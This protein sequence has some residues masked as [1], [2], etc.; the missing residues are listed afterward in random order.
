MGI[1]YVMPKKLLCLSII[2]FIGFFIFG[3][4]RTTDTGIYT[5]G[6]G[7]VVGKA[8][9]KNQ[10]THSGIVVSVVGT[11]FLGTTTTSSGDFTLS[12]VPAGTIIVNY[13]KKGYAGQSKSISV[14][15]DST[16]TVTKVSLSASCGHISGTVKLEGQ[17]DYSGI[18]I[19]VDGTGFSTSTNALGAYYISDLS[20]GNIN[21]TLSKSGYVSKTVTGNIEEGTTTNITETTLTVVS[22]AKGSIT[23][24][25][26]LDGTATSGITVEVSGTSTTVQTD[27]NGQFSVTDLTTGTYTLNYGFSGY[28]TGSMQV[29]V[30]AGQTMS[31]A[32]VNL[33]SSTGTI[34]GLIILAGTS[35]D[36]G[37]LVEVN[38]TSLNATTDETGSY[39]ISDVPQGTYSLTISKA[40]YMTVTTL[41]ISVT[42]GL[43]TS[44]SEITVVRKLEILNEY[45]LADLGLGGTPLSMTYLDDYLYISTSEYI[46]KLSNVGPTVEDQ[47]AVTNN[48]VSMLSAAYDG[49]VVTGDNII[50]G[51]DS[52]G[53]EYEYD[54][55]L[56]L[57]EVGDESFISTSIP[58]V[59]YY[60]GYS[61]VGYEDQSFV[62]A[63]VLVEDEESLPSQNIPVDETG[64]VSLF[65]S[66]DNDLFY[67]CNSSNIYI[68][69]FNSVDF[70]LVGSQSLSFLG[71]GSDCVGIVCDGVAVWTLDAT[72]NKLYRHYLGYY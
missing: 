20:T 12:G 42:A 37:A 49:V 29:A 69:S 62:K 1:I 38:G 8:E 25:V 58:A 24:F 11:S 9:L 61:L 4:S 3:C 67:A 23:G 71:T 50:F 53:Y 40:G 57:V 26:T 35:I 21:L 45:N 2:L 22:S 52:E 56:N 27:S 33:T 65:Y 41:N 36:S 39:T 16:I 64:I 13:T 44:V 32:T 46:Y 66:F 63:S 47:E 5:G 7:T 10:D 48:Y 51:F 55:D 59:T 15:R 68:Y 18:T 17:T 14:V 28:V 70:T 72:T 6:A 34:T 30:N 60:A 19:E 54:E 43:S 31:V